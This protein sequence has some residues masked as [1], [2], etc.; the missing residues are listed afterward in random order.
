LDVSRFKRTPEP[1]YSPDIAPSDF[2]FSA[3]WKPNLNGENIM[4]KMNYMK[5]WV[6]FWQVSHFKWSK[7]SLSTGWINS[8]AWLMEMVTTV[9]KI[10]QVNFWTELHNGKHVKIEY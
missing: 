2:F 7:Q 1:P 6:K 9:P 3:G 10:S 4:G 8:N 5:Q